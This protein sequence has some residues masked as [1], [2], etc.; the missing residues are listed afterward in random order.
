MTILSLITLT[1]TIFG[2]TIFVVQKGRTVIQRLSGRSQIAGLDVT[3]RF[4]CVRFLAKLLLGGQVAQDAV[5]GRYL[6]NKN[7]KQTSIRH[8]GKLF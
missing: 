7:I 1:P 4:L 3:R 5:Y 2:A 8:I 6:E